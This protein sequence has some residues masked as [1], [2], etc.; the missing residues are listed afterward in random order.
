MPIVEVDGQEIEFPDDMSPDQIK[1]VLRQKFPAPQP[2]TFPQKIAQSWDKRQENVNKAKATADPFVT[3]LYS[4]G[5]ALGLAG[6]VAG[7]AI[8]TVTPEFIKQPAMKALGAVAEFAEPVTK[9]IGEAYGQFK[10]NHPNAAA[11]LETAGNYSGLVPAQLGAPVIAKQGEKL[12]NRASV[13]KYINDESSGGVPRPT[14]IDKAAAMRQ[15]TEALAN[16]SKGLYSDIRVE[17]MR[18]SPNEAG[19]I[20]KNLKSLKPKDDINLAPW[21]ESSASKYADE[22]A[23][24]VMREAPTLSG[25]ISRRADLNSDIR[26]AYKADN[27]KE[28]GK[29]EKVKDALDQVMMNPNT[30]KWQEANHIYAQAA[31]LDEIDDLVFKAQGRAQPANSLDTAINNFL[32]SSKAKSLSDEEWAALKEVTDNGTIE[33]L[34]RSGASG[35]VKGVSGLVGGMV[36]GPAGATVGYLTGHFGSEFVKDAAMMAKLNKLEKFRELVLAR[37]MKELPPEK[38]PLQITDRGPEA[39]AAETR[40]NALQRLKEGRT[41]GLPV[42]K[43]QSG[44]MVGRPDGDVPYNYYGPTPQPGQLPPKLLMPP[45]KDM[46]SSPSGKTRP[47]TAAEQESS[48]QGRA[49]SQELGLTSDIRR[50]ISKKALA[51]KFGPVWDNI[52]ESQKDLIKTQTEFEFRKNKRPLE[53]IINESAQRIKDLQEATG[54]K[55]SNTQMHDAILNAKKK[56]TR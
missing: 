18:F 21:L 5:Q 55:P 56:A 11:L 46:V 28:A 32:L 15:E 24:S 48:A 34:K 36:G 6:D 8:G 19:Q 40:A 51:E 10:G 1:G 52:Q 35:L 3:G 2:T 33:K 54:G 29:L 43:P 31:T 49:R 38:T 26:A 27:A 4:T 30:K 53:D 13:Q 9:P 16:K 25:L 50:L 42:E 37:K 45:P 20:Y 12:L 41:G 47:M 22:I 17:G 44:P 14:K 39:R 7:S 23:E